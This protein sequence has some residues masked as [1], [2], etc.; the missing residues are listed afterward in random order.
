MFT[1]QRALTIQ[2]SLMSAW[3]WCEGHKLPEN[4]SKKLL[5]SNGTQ[6]CT[7]S[8]TDP[9]LSV[10]RVWL[11]RLCSP[12]PCTLVVGSEHNAISEL[13]AMF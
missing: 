3:V 6:L 12:A 5:H 13:I 7:Y 1:G 8:L 2:G 9:S 11:V 10:K 4:V